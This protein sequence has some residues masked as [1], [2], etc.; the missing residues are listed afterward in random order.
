MLI[1]VILR[2][3][4][5]RRQWQAESPRKN[6][7]RTTTMKASCNLLPDNTGN[8]VWN[9]KLDIICLTRCN[10]IF[11]MT[12]IAIILSIY[13]A[14]RSV[15]VSAQGRRHVMSP[16]YPGTTGYQGPASKWINF[17]HITQEKLICSLSCAPLSFCCQLAPVDV[18]YYMINTWI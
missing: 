1:R 11:E 17:H 18:Y 5:T 12:V 9:I 2:K 14:D 16:S 4:R 3:Q 15:D 10:G 7:W 13:I 8:L 6:N